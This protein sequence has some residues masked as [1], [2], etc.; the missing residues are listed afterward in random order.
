MLPLVCAVPATCVAWLQAGNLKFIMEAPKLARGP[1]ESVSLP[2]MT[3]VS[4]CERCLVR[5]LCC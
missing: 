5:A 4:K 1:D 3:E 2:L